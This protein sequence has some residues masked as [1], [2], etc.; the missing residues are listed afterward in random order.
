MRHANR[1]CKTCFLAATLLLAASAAAQEVGY[2]DLTDVGP[3]RLT[4]KKFVPDE[5]CEGGSGGLAASIGCPPATYPFKLSLVG[6]DA[7]NF[8]LG[9]EVII[10]IRL[11]NAGHDPAF[12]PWGTDPDEVELP[13][14]NGKFEFSQADLMVNISP[15]G[16]ETAHIFLRTHLYG[17]KNVAGSLVEVHPGEFVELQIKAAIACQPGNTSCESLKAG[18]AKLSITW[19]ESKISVTYAKCGIETGMTRVRQL[20]SGVTEVEIVPPTPR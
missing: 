19:T 5:S 14:E 2:N 13:D 20:D 6:M 4:N 16:A 10:L 18:P 11:Q 15:A 9:G 12:V 8:P 7:A 1:P 17:C 3:N